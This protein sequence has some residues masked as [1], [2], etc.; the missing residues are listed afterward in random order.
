MQPMI[1]DSQ[2]DCKQLVRWIIMAT[3]S[4]NVIFSQSSYWRSIVSG[5]TVI[6]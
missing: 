1:D 2:L 5:V 3:M 6:H 4:I